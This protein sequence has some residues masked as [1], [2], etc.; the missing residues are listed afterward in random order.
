MRVHH[1]NCGT[2]RPP[3]A[4]LVCHVLLV[5]S[6]AGL[7]LIDTG[8][9]LADVADPRSRLGAPRHLLRPAL[10]RE[11]TA[12]VQIQRLGLRP[13][14][15]RHVVVTHF[16]LDHIGG[17]ADFPH[18]RVHVTAAEADGALRA[19]T[20]RERRRFRSVQWSHGP[21]VVEH[22]PGGESWRGFAAARE[23]TEIGPGFV[24]VPL[25]GHTRGHACVAVDSGSR[26]LLHCGDAFYHR[27]TLAGARVPFGLRLAEFGVA[28]DRA[29]V[30]ANHAR[31][32]ALHQRAE[33]DLTLLS[34][35]DP[36]IYAALSEPA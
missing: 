24:L 10:D 3:G 21:D 1:L 22:G 32:A 9:G 23:L 31:L 7:V 2:M 8:F 29:L 18:A 35:H 5:E 6:D 16:D 34:A 33:P 25:P 36:V 12:V 20:G 30:R 14:D 27:N 11:E 26:W 17:L 4:D 19:P 15:V 28:H 13:S